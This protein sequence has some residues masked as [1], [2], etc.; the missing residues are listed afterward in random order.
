MKNVEGYSDPTA[1]EAW[2]HIKRDE[3]KKR[4]KPVC[5]VVPGEP[6]PQGRPRFARHAGYVQTYDPKR[7]K[8]YKSRILSYVWMGLKRRLRAAVYR[9]RFLSAFTAAFRKAGP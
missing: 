8:N 4:C 1:G 3:R 9:W 6:V 2:A 7:S 5:I